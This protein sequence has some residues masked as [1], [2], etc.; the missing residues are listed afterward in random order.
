L[1]GK[2]FSSF[3][4]VSAPRPSQPD[5]LSRLIKAFAAANGGS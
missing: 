4:E 1:L 5:R 3:W 2:V